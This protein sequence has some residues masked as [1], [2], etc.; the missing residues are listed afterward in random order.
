MEKQQFWLISQTSTLLSEILTL[1]SH[2]LYCQ[3]ALVPLLL[4]YILTES[5]WFAFSN[6]PVYPCGVS[7]MRNLVAFHNHMTLCL[8]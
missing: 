3:V 1:D 4:H 8:D 2:C 7:C 6:L 5:F